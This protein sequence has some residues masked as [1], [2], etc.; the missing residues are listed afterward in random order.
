[1]ASGGDAG[2]QWLS[3]QYIEHAIRGWS[4]SSVI[5][6]NANCSF[7]VFSFS[8]SRDLGGDGWGKGGHKSQGLDLGG[9]ENK[10]VRGSLCK[11][12]E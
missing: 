9:L 3:F 6:G 8:Q 5:M 4:H 11:I 10:C 7:L 2:A 1:M 12:P